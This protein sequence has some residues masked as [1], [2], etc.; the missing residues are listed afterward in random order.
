MDTLLRDLRYS[1]TRLLKNPAFTLI[2]VLCL[3]L[4][5]GINSVVFSAVYAIVLSPLPFENPDELVVVNST[6]QQKNIGQ[7]DVS[8]PDYLDF[9]DQSQAFRQLAAFDKFNFNLTGDA[10]PERVQGSRVTADLFPM[11]GVNPE[12]GRYIQAGEDRPGANRVAVI[13]HG[14]WQRR[15][16]SDP[17]IVNKTISLDGEQYDV[18][19][20][21]PASFQFPDKTVELWAPLRVNP[22]PA[23]RGSRSFQ[24]VGRVKP[25]VTAERAASDLATVAA[26]LQQQYPDTNTGWGVIVDGLHD[27]VVED[28]RPALFILVAAVIFVLLIACANVANLLLGQAAAR[29][30]EMALRSALGASRRRLIRQLLTESVLLAVVSGVIG[31]CIAFWGNSLFVSL[32]PANVPRADQIG[33]NRWVLAFTLAISIL[34]GVVFGLIPALSASKPDLNETLKEGGRSGTGGVRQRVRSLLVVVELALALMLLINAGLMIKSLLRIREVKTGFNPS[35]V[36]TMQIAL[37]RARYGEDAQSNAFYQ[38]LYERVKGMPGAVSAGLVSS[39]PLGGSNVYV[40]FTAEGH[41]NDGE[42]RAPARRLAVSPGY[43]RTMEIPVVKGREFTEQDTATSQPVAMLN[44]SLA[45]QLWPDGDA[46]GKRIKLGTAE[47]DSP[48]MSVVGIAAD[49]KQNGLNRSAGTDIYMPY[50][51]DPRRSMALVVRT[52]SDPAGLVS[53]VRNEVRG[54]D[55]NQPVYNVRTMEQVTEESV[56]GQ[57]I[58][59][60]MLGLFATLA[61]MLAV[62]G[63]Y[64]VMSYSVN[65]RRREIG[66]RMALGAKPRHVLRMIVGQGMVLVIVGVVVGLLLAFALTR[67]MESLLFGVSTTDAATFAGI[68]L[69]LSAVALLSCFIPARR[70][71]KVN[72]A[73]ILRYE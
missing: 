64:G 25:G 54:V 34:T 6:N 17:Q 52:R 51:Q 40:F 27:R 15:F 72:P 24:V 12:R 50:V 16:G 49:S 29:Q 60:R 8:M 36:L 1:F 43:F 4:N 7:V 30:K 48:W 14:L 35:N 32:L 73:T 56:A 41:E 20:V 67:V 71:A 37:P 2:A 69:L 5:I 68:S 39:L 22:D 42:N 47:V 62:A 59:A 61:L 65:Q 44:E 23:L 53:A 33:V 21:M 57:R 28:F 19:G 45:K 58:F 26:R 10:E 13:S 70:A 3:A 66:V 55:A 46:I 11:L 18:V 38:Q 31:L 9:R 63:I